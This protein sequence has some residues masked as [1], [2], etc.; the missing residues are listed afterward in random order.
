MQT[1]SPE[2]SRKI[3]EISDL[4]NAGDYLYRGE[5][6]FY[7]AVSST[8][9][10]QYRGRVDMAHFD[11]DAVQEE[12]LREAREYTNRT[13]D[14]AEI[15]HEMQHFGGKTNLVDFTT[16][17]LLAL[18]FACD[19]WHEHDGRVIL[20]RV[21]EA[22]IRQR[23]MPRNP[24]NRVIAQKSVFIRPP[25]GFI[26]AGAFDEVRV[27]KAMKLPM[28]DYLDSRHGI[29]TQSVYNDLHGF[30]E[31]KARAAED[32]KD[33]EIFNRLPAMRPAENNHERGEDDQD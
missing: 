11:A 9:Y 21:S 14:D 27:P 15:L 29:R 30:I 4:T 5:P 24:P 17:F 16:D 23:Q 8:L 26:P 32:G 3:R 31:M 2:V 25:A 7:D 10:R 12:I 22:I 13:D 18:F 1:S 33:V 28:L 6:Q 19:G 20:L